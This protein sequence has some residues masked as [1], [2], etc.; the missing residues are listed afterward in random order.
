MRRPIS[1]TSLWESLLGLFAVLVV[2][3]PERPVS[4]SSPGD[5]PLTSGAG[6]EDP[7]RSIPI[8]TD[9]CGAT[10]R[11]ASDDGGNEQ[12]ARRATGE[13]QQGA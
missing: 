3:L 8:R 13:G 12:E 2:I 7:I 1:W 6:A 5:S 11:A 10:R 4:G 9:L